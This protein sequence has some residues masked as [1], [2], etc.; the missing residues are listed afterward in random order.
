MFYLWGVH[1]EVLHQESLV[2]GQTHKLLPQIW[3]SETLKAHWLVFTGPVNTRLPVLAL[4]Q[5]GIHVRSYVCTV[6]RYVHCI[7]AFCV[8][9]C[10]T[11]KCVCGKRTTV[12]VL[13]SQIILQKSSTVL[14]RGVWLTMNSLLWWCPCENT[15]TVKILVL[16]VKWKSINSF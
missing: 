6:E 9:V 13:C 7:I 11:W 4:K 12:C 5:T 15:S 1:C 16:L 8:R 10:Y 14:L 2:I 3:H